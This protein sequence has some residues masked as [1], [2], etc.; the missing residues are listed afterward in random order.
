MRLIRR[1]PVFTSCGPLVE[2]VELLEEGEEGYGQYVR[3]SRQQDLA[4]TA[5]SNT[6]CPMCYTV[7]Y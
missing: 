3:N 5:Q 6:R 1:P 4:E 2:L 7:L